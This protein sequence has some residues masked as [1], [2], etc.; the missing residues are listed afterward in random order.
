MAAT[1]QLEEIEGWVRLQLL[2]TCG[3]RRGLRD[4]TLVVQHEC[5]VG[6]HL[7]ISRFEFEHKVEYLFRLLQVAVAPVDHAQRV[8]GAQEPGV[9]LD[10]RARPPIG[11]IDLPQSEQLG[12]AVVHVHRDDGFLA[13]D[14]YALAPD[15][16]PRKKIDR[17]RR[18]LVV[19]DSAAQFL[20]Q[21]QIDV[22]DGEIH[23]AAAAPDGISKHHLVPDGDTDLLR[24]R[25]GH[26]DQGQAI[27]GSCAE[28]LRRVPGHFRVVDE[29]ELVLL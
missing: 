5:Q 14:A 15:I 18:A 21:R 13:D 19:E 7:G 16:F 3:Q 4:A 9:L 17:Q 10:G 8:V 6:H 23:A 1:P 24:E 2:A 12:C 26:D 27:A 22:R 29:L 28:S 20:P 25:G 11:V